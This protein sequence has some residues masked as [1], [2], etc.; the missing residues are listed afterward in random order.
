M[1]VRIQ[2]NAKK[3]N[4]EINKQSNEAQILGRRVW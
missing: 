4:G 2:Y 3:K 1:V